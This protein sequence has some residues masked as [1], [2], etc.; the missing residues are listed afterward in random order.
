[1]GLGVFWKF[2]NAD[3]YYHFKL[4]VVNGGSLTG[5]Y[6]EWKQKFNPFGLRENDYEDKAACIVLANTINLNLNDPT[7]QGFNSLVYNTP[8]N[9]AAPTT[10]FHAD[11]RTG[12]FYWFAIGLIQSFG[13]QVPIV[14]SNNVVSHIKLFM[15][16][17]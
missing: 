10:L 11:N 15:I 3:G 6:F 1:M 16:K 9:T 4:E 17:E 5:R 14:E 13:G 8:S 12:N 7:G 2:K